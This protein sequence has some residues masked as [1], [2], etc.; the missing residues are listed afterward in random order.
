MSNAKKV[1]P[2]QT[3][4]PYSESNEQR[5]QRLYKS[6]G[7]PLLGWL[8]DEAHNRGQTL[9]QMSKELGVTYGYIAQLRSGLRSQKSISKVFAT[10]C[11]RYLGVPTVVI[12]LLS[13][14]LTLRDF[15]SYEMDEE[16][17]LNRALRKMMQDPQL[18]IVLGAVDLL[19]LT[20]ES[21]RMLV[22]IY[23]EFLGHDYLGGPLLPKV[24]GFLQRAA[25]IHSERELAL[26]QEEVAGEL[27]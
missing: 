9:Q 5:V 13:G 2:Q 16:A 7:G 26:L 25:V 18:L 17:Q 10:S 11:A 22:N 8:E 1:R 3:R 12:L 4:A 23:G 15:A 19:S 27:I 20:L 21:K 6:E 24:V 14:F